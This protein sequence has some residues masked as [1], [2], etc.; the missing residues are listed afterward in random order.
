MRAS[1][2]VASIAA[3]SDPLCNNNN[4]VS[5]LPFRRMEPPAVILPVGS[6]R[7]SPESGSCFVFIEA[8]MTIISRGGFDSVDLNCAHYSEWNKLAATLTVLWVFHFHF[9][10]QIIQQ[11]NSAISQIAMHTAKKIRSFISRPHY[12]GLSHII[13]LAH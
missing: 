4:Q 12:C 1:C 13:R 3:V 9:P 11:N 10:P 8:L 7:L 2:P 5:L 6:F